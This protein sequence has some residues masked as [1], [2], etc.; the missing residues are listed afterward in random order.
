MFMYE[1]YNVLETSLLSIEC[2]FCRY[3]YLD[4]LTWYLV[5]QSYQRRSQ[6][7]IPY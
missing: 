2:K 7:T 3:I 5:W 6:I 1:P 4:L